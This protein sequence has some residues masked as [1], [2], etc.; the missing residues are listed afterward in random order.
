M[1]CV[2]DPFGT[3]T[4]LFDSG[5][6]TQQPST[7]HMNLHYIQGR[8][9]EERRQMALLDQSFL[10]SVNDDERNRLDGQMKEC[11]ASIENLLEIETMLQILEYPYGGFPERPFVSPAKGIRETWHGGSHALIEQEFVDERNGDRIAGMECVSPSEDD[12]LLEPG[13]A[14]TEVLP[15]T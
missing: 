13:K 6:R 14:E 5:W 10:D 9:A 8:I 4:L 7:A 11:H 15:Q 12:D 3:L 2:G 1:W